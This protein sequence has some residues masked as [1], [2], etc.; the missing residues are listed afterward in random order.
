M[1]AVS[2]PHR[3][4]FSSTEAALQNAFELLSYLSTIIWS[5]PAQFRYPI[6]ISAIAVYAAALAYT[7]FLRRSRGHLIHVHTPLCLKGNKPRRSRSRDQS[8]G[9]SGDGV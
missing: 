9:V 8:P 3:G 7:V 5:H 2:S 4:A 6:L 1:Q